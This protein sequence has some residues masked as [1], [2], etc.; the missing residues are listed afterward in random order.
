M[1]CIASN[2]GGSTNSNAATLTVTAA[3]GGTDYLENAVLMNAVADGLY[4]SGNL[5]PGGKTFTMQALVI[6]DEGVPS[7]WSNGNTIAGILYTGRQHTIGINGSQQFGVRNNETTNTQNFPVEQ[8]KWYLMSL[9]SDSG[10][11]LGG[12]LRLTFQEYEGESDP[13]LLVSQQVK[14]EYFGANNAMQHM[15][16]GAAGLFG[17][18]GW[19]RGVRMQSMRCYNHVRTDTQ[20]RADRR[21]TN[22]A[23]SLWWWDAVDN[24]SGGLAF[25]DRSGNNVAP[26][27]AGTLELA[28]GPSG[29]GGGSG[30]APSF[31]TQPTS[32]TV[33]EDTAFNFTVVVTGDPAPTLEWQR[34]ISG[35]WTAVGDTDNAFGGTATLAMNGYQYRCAATNSVGTVYSDTV[36]LTVEAA[37]GGVMGITGVPTGSVPGNSDRGL[38]TAFTKGVGRIN[39]I[40]AQ[41]VAESS[42]QPSA[43]RV[44]CYSIVGWLPRALLWATPL[45]PIPGTGGEVEFDLP[46]EGL[47]STD[48]AGIYA[49]AV[50]LDDFPQR[51]A[52]FVGQTGKTTFV[53]YGSLFIN[54]PPA[55]FPTTDTTYQDIALA[56]AAEYA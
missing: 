4:R 26:V 23:G 10:E 54:P 51:F 32:Q 17:S 22:P 52:T 5:F 46:T 12:I 53:S 9:T 40:T 18:S 13:T 20:L 34:N 37:S 6:F 14:G 36:T 15:A 11:S 50:A 55:T 29:S 33:L 27:T 24:G 1:R 21:N 25:V 30:T 8:G 42:Q 7:S 16:W 39:R 49:L 38:A 41:F 19:P 31:T 35:T 2:A 43:A 47:E 3:G 48:E 45:A 44:Y 28:A 56:V